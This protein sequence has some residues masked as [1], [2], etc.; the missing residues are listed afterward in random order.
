MKIKPTPKLSAPDEPQ[1]RLKQIL[2]SK[3]DLIPRINNEGLALFNSADTSAK[4]KDYL[5]ELIS[6][7]VASFGVPSTTLID[8]EIDTLSRELVIKDKYVYPNM[9]SKILN[10]EKLSQPNTRE[11]AMQTKL[12]ECFENYMFI[13]LCSTN[14]KLTASGLPSEFFRPAL[15]I[16]SLALGTNAHFKFNNFFVHETL[17]FT[18]LHVL[19]R[20]IKQCLDTFLNVYMLKDK[21]NMTNGSIESKAA[22]ETKVTSVFC[23]KKPSNCK[24]IKLEEIRTSTECFRALVEYSRGNGLNETPCVLVTV[25]ASVYL[26]I[27]NNNPA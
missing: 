8:G 9:I 2:K 13:D 17:D 23:L 3:L 22:F 11:T 1:S 7:T 26:S 10:D 18:D 15:L 27:K 5:G 20:D 21:F 19:K 6:I 25:K 4:V 14:G 24:T 16:F 12:N